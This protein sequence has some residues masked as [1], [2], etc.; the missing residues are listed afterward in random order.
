MNLFIQ[1]STVDDTWMTLI[2]EIFNQDMEW[3]TAQINQRISIRPN[4]KSLP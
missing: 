3:F 4:A 2:E 1:I